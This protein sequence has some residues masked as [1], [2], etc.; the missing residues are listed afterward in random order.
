M[1]TQT[2][3]PRRE[4]RPVTAGIAVFI[5]GIHCGEVDSYLAADK[6]AN[7]IISERQSATGSP[8]R[9]CDAAP[10]CTCPQCCP[11]SGETGHFYC[12][13]DKAFVAYGDGRYLGSGNAIHALALVNNHRYAK[14]RG[15]TSDLTPEDVEALVAAEMIVA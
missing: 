1:T 3:E 7:E 11:Q 10:S 6:L 5:D 9:R 2:R 8:S 14:L 12:K 4:L 13:F 15:D